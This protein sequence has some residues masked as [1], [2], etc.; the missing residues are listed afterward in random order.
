MLDI[1]RIFLCCALWYILYYE[2]MC[3]LDILFAAY[4]LLL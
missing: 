1:V 4:L 3:T 2:A